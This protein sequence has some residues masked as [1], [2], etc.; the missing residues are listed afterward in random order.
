MMETTFKRTE[1]HRFGGCMVDLIRN[2]QQPVSYKVEIIAS[3]VDDDCEIE[4]ANQQRMS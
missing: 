1:K 3:A 4:K 2:W